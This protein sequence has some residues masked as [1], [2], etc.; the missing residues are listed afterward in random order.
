MNTAR[1]VAKEMCVNKAAAKRE[2]HHIAAIL[3][4][5]QLAAGEPYREPNSWVE[6]PDADQRRIDRALW[7]LTLY[8][9]QRA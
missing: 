4:R 9:E 6:R 5:N 1:L 8:H 2:A 7:N 3:I